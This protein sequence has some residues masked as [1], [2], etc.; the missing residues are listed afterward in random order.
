MKII[1]TGGGTGGHVT[2][3]V[4]IGEEIRSTVPNTEILFIGRRGGKEN[5][6]VTSAGMRVETVEIRG[7][8]RSASL[9]NLKSAY[10]AVKAYCSAKKIIRAYSP[11]VIVG[12][13]GY[14]TWP[15]VRAG[16]ALGIPT[17][18]HESNVTPGLVTRLLAKGCNKVLLN[19]A[20]AA[21]ALPRANTV[22]TGNPIRTDFGRITRDEA[23]RRLGASPSDTVIVSFGGSGGSD[24]MND[25]ITEV[26]RTYTS[27]RGNIIHI[28]ATGR[29][30]Y[31]KYS[32]R[33]A[34]SGTRS[35][36]LPFINNM[37]QLLC[38][39]DIAITRCG[40]LTLSEL[41]C[42]G[43]ASIL[44]PSPNV[45]DD[46]QRKNGELMANG[47]GA[48]LIE[49]NDLTPD[50]LKT[51]IQR[52][53]RDGALRTRMSKCIEKFANRDARRLCCEHIVGVVKNASVQRSRRQ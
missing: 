27:K 36:I 19:H 43:V 20:E 29:S 9:A 46:H 47:G 21:K 11:D 38:A 1:L 42:V 8:K 7:L 2:P 48:V 26:M 49:E 22:V 5:E 45:T 51:E 14:V 23:R 30:Y 18:M 44:I 3:A 10:L 15:V 25:V 50:R 40:A 41:S 6:A 4:S 37:P 32:G 24:R 13:G 33:I 53:E 12:T 31:E 17:V 16:Q 39:A 52:L 28:H 34:K 35:Q